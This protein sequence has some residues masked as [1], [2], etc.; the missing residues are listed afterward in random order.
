MYGRGIITVKLMVV[1]EFSFT[2]IHG[3]S[4]RTIAPRLVCRMVQF[5]TKPLC[6]FTEAI[7]GIQLIRD[8]FLLVGQS[9][10][11]ADIST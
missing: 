9:I 8:I 7:L 1:S 11:F 6:I 4:Q 10:R 5:A 3:G 2:L